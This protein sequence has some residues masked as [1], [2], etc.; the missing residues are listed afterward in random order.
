L[1]G[2]GSGVSSIVATTIVASL[3]SL[4]SVAQKEERENNKQI[5]T[6]RNKK[7]KSCNWGPLGNMK[8]RF[9]FHFNIKR[10]CW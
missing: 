7:K 3:G 4:V 2:D 5:R 6:N 9:Q 1:G 8:K 10:P